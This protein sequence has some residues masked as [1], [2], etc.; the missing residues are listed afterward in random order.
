MKNL[1][2]KLLRN[3]SLFS[4]DRK[5]KLLLKYIGVYSIEM[6]EQTFLLIANIFKNL[7]ISIKD[8]LL[9]EID[10]GSK[11]LN[12]KSE[13]ELKIIEYG[14]FNWCTWFAKCGIKDSK[15]DE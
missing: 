8:K 5:C 12:N 13:E 9:D 2:I 15:I 4:Y 3:S 7:S 11:S 10:K 14:K 6:K 1:G